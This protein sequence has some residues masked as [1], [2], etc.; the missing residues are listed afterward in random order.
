MFNREKRRKLFDNDYGNL[1][2][3]RSHAEKEEKRK[4]NLR[5]ISS[6]RLVQLSSVRPKEETRETKQSNLRDTGSIAI[7]LIRQR[8][9][10]CV[11]PLQ[12]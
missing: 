3:H 10:R 1:S 5:I 7:S 4:I 9:L 12:K 6:T 2:V 8:P 11:R